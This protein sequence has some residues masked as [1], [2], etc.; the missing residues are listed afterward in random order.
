MCE[1]SPLGL[2]HT[3]NRMSWRP[4]VV[5][6]L[7]MNS[8]KTLRVCGDLKTRPKFVGSDSWGQIFCQLSE[9]ERE[10]QEEGGQSEGGR[11]CC[12]HE[13]HALPGCVCAHPRTHAPEYLQGRCARWPGCRAGGGVG[14][15]SACAANPRARWQ[16]SL[17][18]DPCA[19]IILLT[20]IA[21]PVQWRC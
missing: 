2:P 12:T 3:Q 16:G 13:A 7:L 5:E 15:A 14:D 10:D 21:V 20:P 17:S 1:R 9:T 4:R 19:Q 18:G 8:P 6:I 11:S